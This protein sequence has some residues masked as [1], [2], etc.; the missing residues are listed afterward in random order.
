MSYKISL[1]PKKD[2]NLE[3]ELKLGE[4]SICFFKNKKSK[5]KIKLKKWKKGL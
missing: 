5:N 2:L 4:E 1:S 3:E